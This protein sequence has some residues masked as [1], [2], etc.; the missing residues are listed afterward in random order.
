M[1]S[2]LRKLTRLSCR[3]LIA[4][5]VLSLPA[6]ASEQ[7]PSSNPTAVQPDGRAGDP[8]GIDSKIAWFNPDKLAFQWTTFLVTDD[9]RLIIVALVGKNYSPEG[10]L[11]SGINIV[12]VDGP[13]K[14]FDIQQ[15]L[16]DELVLKET[17]LDVAI[18]KNSIVKRT[19]GTDK[20]YSINFAAKDE[21]NAI[22]IN[23][24]LTQTIAPC[25]QGG[26]PI[27]SQANE[28][29]YFEYEEECP[30]ALLSG[31]M[32]INGQQERLA[33]S[34]HIESVRW[35]KSTMLKPMEWQWGFAEMDS[36]FVLFFKPD[37][38]E[39]RSLLLVSSKDQCLHALEGADFTL[40]EDAGNKKV[41][42]SH[43]NDELDLGLDIDT[44]SLDKNDFFIN[45]V[46]ATL[47]LGKQDGTS[48]ARQGL[49]VYGKGTWKNF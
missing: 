14:T 47:T 29:S 46:P 31:V 49:M 12:V 1:K 3:L 16:T 41:V 48:I 35:L 9:H 5:A 37:Y 22:T 13:K 32:Q 38:P 10:V 19:T 34:G 17:D 42:L 33:G 20:Y 40:R 25:L 39:A 28:Q 18:G 15:T 7:A 8:F 4:L 23:A 27:L 2:A 6:L 26:S 21:T 36:S 43:G 11:F 44:A 45:I 24:E 30:S